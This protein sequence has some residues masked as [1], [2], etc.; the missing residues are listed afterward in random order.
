MSGAAAG[1]GTIA[2]TLAIGRI[3]DQYSFAP[4][5]IGASLLPVVAT[6]LVFALVRNPVNSE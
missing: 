5:L 2:S 1:I 3:T 6:V 4:V